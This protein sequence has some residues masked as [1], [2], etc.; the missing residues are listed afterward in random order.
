MLHFGAAIDN[1]FV[2]MRVSGV[3]IFSLLAL[4]VI[5]VSEFSCRTRK[6]V[7]ELSSKDFPKYSKQWLKTIEEEEEE[8]WGI[9]HKSWADSVFDAMS[10]DERI[11]QLMMVAA[12]SNRDKKH[13]DEITRLITENHI[14]GVIFFQGGPL[15]QANLNNHFQSVSKVPLFVSIDGEWGLSMRLDSTIQYP[16]QMT[17]G[18]I[19]NDSLIYQMGVR[20]ARECKRMGMQINFAPVLDINSNP[21]NPVIGFRSFGENKYKV[22]RKGWAYMKGMQ[23]EKVIANGKHFPGHGDTDKDSH[24][25]LPMLPHTKAR[26]DSME[27]FPFKML[28]DSGLRSI[29]VAHL[30]V[31]C[32]DTSKNCAASISKNIV[33]KTLKDS[34]K[35]RGLVFTDALNMKG[36]S[37]FYKPGELEVKAI[38]AGNDVLLFPEDVPAAVVA[39]KKAINDGILKEADINIRCR[40]ILLAKEWSGVHRKNQIDKK[41]LYE[42]LN[43][44]SAQA[45]NRR[46]FENALTLLSNKDNLLPLKRLDTLRIATVS[47]GESINDYTFSKTIKN[48]AKADHFKLKMNGK[49]SNRDSLLKVLPNYHVVLV[50]VE[51]ITRKSDKNY[52]FSVE[53]MDFI[54]RVKAHS[55]T[56]LNLMGNP[57]SLT[58]FIGAENLDAIIVSYENNETTASLGA[59]LVFGAVD[60][61]GRL[62]VTAGWAFTAGSGVS[63]GAP[64]RL[65]YAMPEELGIQA[66]RL[67]EVDRIVQSGIS[68]GA[69]PGCQVLAAKDGRIFYSKAFG[70]MSQDGK[71]KVTEQTIYDL[72]SLT[73]VLSTTL[74]TM[75]NT[76]KGLIDLN[77][78]LATYY[79][80]ASKSDKAEL[81]IIDLLTH[82]SGLK[83][84]IPYY[85][86]TMDKGKPSAK[87]YK[88]KSSDKFPWAVTD[89]LFMRKDYPDTMYQMILRSDKDPIGKYVYSDI[90]FYL[91]HRINEQASKQSLQSQVESIY[92]TIGAY[93]L[94]YQPLRTFPKN[95]I[96]PTERDM[97][98]RKTLVHGYVHDPGAAMLGGVAGHAGL[99]GTATDVAKVAQLMLNKGKYAGNEYFSNETFEKFNQSPFMAEGNRRGLGFDKPDT[100]PGK[101]SPT[102]PSASPSSFGHSGFT[103]AFFWVDPEYNLV[104]VFLSNRVHPDAENKKLVKMGIRTRALEEFY[105]A[106]RKEKNE[107][108]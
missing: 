54:N 28:I 60:S 5:S 73:K 55:K 19:Q 4:T 57:Y 41:N 81:K 31:P 74:A 10:L 39:I 86:K 63:L 48:Y 65:G 69:Y 14:G 75:V 104:Y 76:D 34:L 1:N 83:A 94:M 95:I 9:P 37:A 21:K 17:L 26:L 100:R 62:P 103:G 45:L 79:P 70:K 22:A 92:A 32:L 58:G 106:I 98:F 25:S 7:S 67:E 101:D 102:A 59:Q 47:I 29:M 97:T 13:K 91:M 38:F 44:R 68:E 8:Y 43:D 108:L 46:L 50:S 87:Y 52:N 77:E 64:I 15:R 105:Q 71:D 27:L 88:T 16:R 72:A 61:P 89:S 78:K 49:K 51:N 66:A 12:Y 2:V 42:D 33:N 3:I 93:S 107:G 23:D 36:V 30:E 11:G 53:S 85:L 96:A 35:F 84:F 99:F 90:N 82:R 24:L 6:E 80:A 56:I 40:K 18:A 20:I